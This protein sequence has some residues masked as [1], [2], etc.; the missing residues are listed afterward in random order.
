MAPSNPENDVTASIVVEDFG[1]FGRAFRETDLAE[2]DLNTIV[3]NMM[4]GEYR[5]PLRVVAFNSSRLNTPET[6]PPLIPTNSATG[7]LVLAALGAALGAAV[8]PRHLEHRS[9]RNSRSRTETGSNVRR[10]AFES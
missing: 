8:G 4:A 1:Q 6:T 9:R 10:D 2:A 5:N 7:P 3:R